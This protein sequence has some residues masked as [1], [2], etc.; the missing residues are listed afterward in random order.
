M[1]IKATVFA[2]QI[3]PNKRSGDEAPIWYFEHIRPTDDTQT[4]N[5]IREAVDVMNREEHG[6][7]RNGLPNLERTTATSKAERDEY[8]PGGAQTSE[9]DEHQAQRIAKAFYAQAES[10]FNPTIYCTQGISQ[11]PHVYAARNV[12]IEANPALTHKGNGKRR[13]QGT[14]GPDHPRRDPTDQPQRTARPPAPAKRITTATGESDPGQMHDLRPKDK[15][16]R[17]ARNY[18][19]R[20]EELQDHRQR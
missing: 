14:V 8:D 11:W 4:S 12:R 18:R 16:Q 6:H 13:Y 10:T 2:M 1:A 20:Q 19:R 7:V 3:V 5:G 15:I 9:G 17:T